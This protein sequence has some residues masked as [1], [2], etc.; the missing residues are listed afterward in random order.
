MKILVCDDE[1]LIRKVI[2][3]Y[4]ELESFIIIE[5]TDGNDALTK[6]KNND[7]DLIIMV[8][9]RAVLGIDR[10][11]SFSFQ[12]IGIHDSFHDFFMFL[13]DVGLSQ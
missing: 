10:D 3:E 4:L 2:K 12:I 7:I 5:A 9:D 8:F 11:P 6:V 13:K 1:E